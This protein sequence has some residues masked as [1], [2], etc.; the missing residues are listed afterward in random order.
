MKE[1]NENGDA[2]EQTWVPKTKLARRYG[3][4]P[5]TI[6]NWQALGLLVFFKVGRVVRFDIAGSD[7]SLKERGLV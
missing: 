2:K 7:A 3:V 4:S 1:I 5:R 6:A